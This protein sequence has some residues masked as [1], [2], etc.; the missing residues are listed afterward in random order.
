MNT[1]FLLNENI[2]DLYNKIKQRIIHQIQYDID[3]KTQYKNIVNKLLV[4][5]SKKKINNL[6]KLN[7][8]ALETICPYLIS[9]ISNTKSNVEFLKD[10]KISSRNFSKSISIASLKKN[11][12]VNSS[13]IKELDSYEDSNNIS[14][15]DPSSESITQDNKNINYNQSDNHDIEYVNNDIQLNDDDNV[16]SNN[17][18]TSFSLDD[19]FEV[20]D[21]NFEITQPK[22]DNTNEN[23]KNNE[24]SIETFQNFTTESVPK[25]PDSNDTLIEIMSKLVSEVKTQNELFSE[26][27]KELKLINSKQETQIKLLENQNKT[28]YNFIEHLSHSYTANTYEKIHIDLCR[29][30]NNVNGSNHFGGNVP[31][32]NFKIELNGGGPNIK[33]KVELY[34]ED[35]F[36]HKFVLANGFKLEQLHHITVFF[37]IDGLSTVYTNNTKLNTLPHIIIPNESFGYTDIGS[38]HTAIVDTE[39]SGTDPNLD[40]ISSK[41]RTDQ[42]NLIYK[43]K[44]YYIGTLCKKIKFPDTFSISLKGAYVSD[45]IINNLG[46]FR[47]DFLFAEN[48][49]SRCFMNILLKNS[50]YSI[51]N[52][53]SGD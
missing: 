21:T 26:N 24:E 6:E 27:I 25:P 49:N 18:I 46:G 22:I 43:P 37:H 7:S 9:K 36:I 5:I 10:N 31:F 53:K 17:E 30:S 14:Y 3:K 33:N 23:N 4:K 34:L 13:E 1:Q 2:D 50:D 42:E 8:L 39:A 52:S 41:K 19:Q 20:N 12:V 28:N 35:F 51:K 32:D 11:N 16:K 29:F 38:E 15:I 45:E 47:N 44:S 48:K 40:T